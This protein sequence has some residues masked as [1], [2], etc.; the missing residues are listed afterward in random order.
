M[1]EEYSALEGDGVVTVCLQL[2]GQSSVDVSVQLETVAGSGTATGMYCNRLYFYSNVTND[3]NCYSVVVLVSLHIFGA[4]FQ[5]AL[6]MS[7]SLDQWCFQLLPVEIHNV[8][9]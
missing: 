9:I 8:R 3:I 2:I 5:L 7:H 4:F 1:E 6:T